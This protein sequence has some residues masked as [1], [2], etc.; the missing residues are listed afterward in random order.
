MFVWKTF[1]QVE[2]DA[3]TSPSLKASESCR[4]FIF[5]T[6]ARTMGAAVM[7]RKQVFFSFLKHRKALHL[8]L[9]KPRALEPHTKQFSYCSGLVGQFT[10]RCSSFEKLYRMLEVTEQQLALSGQITYHLVA[11]GSIS[12]RSLLPART[13]P[14]VL[15]HLLQHKD[16]HSRS[17]AA[18]HY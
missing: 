12:T 5:G 1:S 3:L 10:T 18:E 16:R 15:G 2:T 17:R 8:L 9:L 14:F 6:S 11:D 7:E 13:I 4:T